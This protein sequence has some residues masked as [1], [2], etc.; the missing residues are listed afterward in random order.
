[1][2]GKYLKQMFSVVAAKKKSSGPK[3]THHV[4]FDIS[5]GGGF[6]SNQY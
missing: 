6:Q 4:F 5:I 1:M 3:I 2:F